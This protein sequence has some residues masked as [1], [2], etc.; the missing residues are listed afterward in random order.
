MHLRALGIAILF[1]LGVLVV[2][3]R[4]STGSVLD[5]PK[6]NLLVQLSRSL[7]Q[8]AGE[9]EAHAQRLPLPGERGIL[10]SP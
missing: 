1:L 5:K 9:G 3:K 4:V 6:G 2:V 8:V 10:S 7:H